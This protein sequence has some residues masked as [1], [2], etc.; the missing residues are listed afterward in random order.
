MQVHGPKY[1]Y[2]IKLSILFQGYV[3]CRLCNMCCTLCT[4]VYRSQCKVCNVKM[5][6]IGYSVY[7]GYIR[8]TLDSRQW[9]VGS[10]QYTVYSVFSVQY[11][12]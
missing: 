12:V 9:P 2:S 6:L 10:G 8:C 1:V 4:A 5:Q 11:R 7:C 3:K